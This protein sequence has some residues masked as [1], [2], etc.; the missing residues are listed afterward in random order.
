MDSLGVGIMP[1]TDREF[2][3]MRN[4]VY[5]RFGINL[6]DQKRSLL[7]GRLQKLLHTAGFK[8]FKDYYNYLISDSSE[9][10]LIDLINR[11]STNHTFFN[12]EKEHFVYFFDKALPEIVDKIRKKKQP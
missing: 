3:L 2:E 4:L 1:I 12:R 6:T 5:K 9:K 7:V 8:S 10:A 11:I